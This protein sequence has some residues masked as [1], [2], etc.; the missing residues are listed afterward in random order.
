MFFFFSSACRAQLS[1]V[2]DFGR[3]LSMIV[4]EN[5]LVFFFVS[6]FLPVSRWCFLRQHCVY[7]MFCTSSV[8]N[9]GF[10]FGCGLLRI[11]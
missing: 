4:C 11:S 3:L 1:Y 9:E 2:D 6:L 5:N 7:T 10:L 8:V